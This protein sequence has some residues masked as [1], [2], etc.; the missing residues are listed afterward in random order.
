MEGRL[1]FIHITKTAG[2]TIEF[3]GRE[4]HWGQH[5]GEY[6][7]KMRASL[8]WTPKDYWHIP[9]QF[10]TSELFSDLRSHFD[11][12]AVVRNPFERVIS[13]TFC[14][15]AGFQNKHKNKMWNPR[16]NW[17]DPANI[18]AWITYRLNEVQT[19]IQ[20]FEQQKSIV[21]LHVAANETLLCGHWIP[22]HYY[23]VDDSGIDFIQPENVLRFENIARDFQG[24][25]ERYGLSYILGDVHHNKRPEDATFTV[26]QLSEVNIELI[27][28]IYRKDFIKFDY[29][30]EVL[31]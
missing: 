13:E 27:R 12:F 25:M 16:K 6:G 31:R 19:K 21:G 17:K 11:Y 10:M 9:P 8:E 7:K 5:D 28:N 14:K 23:V 4:E 24:L 22:Q 18:N 15:W 26:L 3:V 2:A 30:L 20:T 1:R 29:S